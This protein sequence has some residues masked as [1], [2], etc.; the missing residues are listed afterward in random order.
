MSFTNIYSTMNK[1]L[2][3]DETYHEERAEELSDM[4]P[5]TYVGAN[6]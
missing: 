5:G 3:R 6:L 4:A 2:Y 1:P